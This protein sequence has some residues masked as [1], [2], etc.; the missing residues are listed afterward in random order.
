MGFQKSVTDPN[1][2][3]H[4]QLEEVSSKT[5]RLL[6]PFAYV[7]AAGPAVAVPAH[8]PGETTDLASVPPLL[9]GLL[10]SYG[11]QLRAALMHDHLCDEVK[12]MPQTTPAERAAAYASRRLADH[13]FREA[14]RHGGNGSPTAV[15]ARVGWFRAEMF[16]CGV[17]FGR[18][19]EFR[20]VRAVLLALQ[21]FGGAA[22]VW[23]AAASREPRW[24]YGVAVA[25]LLS[26]LWG[27][28][29]GPALVAVL[30]APVI[31]PVFAVTFLAHLVLAV[32]DEVAKALHPATEPTPAIKP[33]AR[34]L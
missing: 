31:L 22:A 33:T 24:L 10:A 2:P 18:Y 8:G 7:P 9:W 14:L 12:T 32:P 25:V 27:E 30:A 1:P 29:R 15:Q 16:L 20:R 28:D 6:T 26:A 13:L 17:T 5:F 23:V 3:P 11:R 21:A 4:I 34:F 19:A